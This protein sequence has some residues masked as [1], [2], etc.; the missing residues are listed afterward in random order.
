MT[1]R[2][3]FALGQARHHLGHTDQAR[4]LYD[5]ALIGA[6]KR[7]AEQD[8]AAI[9][10]RLGTLARETGDEPQAA[11]HREAAA[12]IRRRNGALS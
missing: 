8:Q 9:H 11:R 3:A 7:N 1:A 2:T 6:G 12:T 10:D 5:E 4:A